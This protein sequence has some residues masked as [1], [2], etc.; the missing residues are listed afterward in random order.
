[1]VLKFLKIIKE[2]IARAKDN[3]PFVRHALL[4]ALE[5]T[6][7]ERVCDECICRVCIL[8][9]IDGPCD[10]HKKEGG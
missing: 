4:D 9:G 5:V 6:I 1:M 10:E 8:L 7:T 2:E 3:T